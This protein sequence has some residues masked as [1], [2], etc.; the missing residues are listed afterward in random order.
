MRE[1]WEL[2]RRQ[3]LWLLSALGLAHFVKP[4]PASPHPKPVP[5]SGYRVL[6]SREVAVLEAIADQIIPP[7]Q[8]PGG[9][10]AGAV[11]YI[12]RV[13]AG[14]QRNK[15]PL[16]TAGVTGTDETSRA[17]FARDFTK[18]EF[19]QQTA[20]LQAIEKGAAQGETW[21]KTSS[22]QFFSTVWLHVL[23]GFY[24]PPDHGGNKDYTSWKMV[25]FP[26]H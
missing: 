6:T 12:D 16:Y 5:A 20:V 19:D 8:D 14:E 21:K 2:S 23:E 10:E 25:G 11:V 17:M 13:L 15:R 26:M 9:R 1:I 18:L 24:G 3:F 7:D 4:L 22:A